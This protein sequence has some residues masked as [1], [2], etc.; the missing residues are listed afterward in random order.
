[1]GFAK[2]TKKSSKGDSPK[3]FVN[4]PG[5]DRYGKWLGYK[6]AKIDRKTLTVTTSLVLRGDH[7]SPSGRVHGGVMAGFFDYSC[8]A[9]TF[10]TMQPQ[11]F[12]STVELKVN[13]FR[14]LDAGNRLRAETKVMFRGKR[15]CVLHS[16]LYRDGEKKPVGMAT[17]TFNIVPPK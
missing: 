12:C 11:D 14:P 8:G 4:Y 5:Q 16:L 1:M 7:L 2:M 15:L 10:M 3:D 13:Y 17:A 6:I 9:A